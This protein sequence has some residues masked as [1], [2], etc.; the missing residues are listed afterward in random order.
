MSV[1]ITVK[2]QGDTDKFRQALTERGEDLVKM[3]DAARAAGAIHHRFSIGDGFIVA[4]DEWESAEQFNA[5]FA[6]PS[7]GAFLGS[8]G[9]APV[10]PEVTIS[11]AV[12]APGD[13]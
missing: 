13:C 4:S 10:P 3:T 12:S 1:L 2:F 8:M 5:F 7:M 9:A 11:E 6:D